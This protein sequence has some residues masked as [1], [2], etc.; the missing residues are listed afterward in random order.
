MGNLPTSRRISSAL[1]NVCES[2]A[3]S[4]PFNS[5]GETDDEAAAR[6]LADPRSGPTPESAGREIRVEGMSVTGRGTPTSNEAPEPMTD[7]EGLTIAY[8][9]GSDDGG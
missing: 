6:G 4:G 3:V 2:D 8:F 1:K 5:H 9:D 7:T